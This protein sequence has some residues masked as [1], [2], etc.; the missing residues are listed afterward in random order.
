MSTLD[1][2]YF[3]YQAVNSAEHEESKLPIPSWIPTGKGKDVPLKF[4]NITGTPSTNCPLAL[5]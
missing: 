5:S 3:C 4:P 1:G 2:K